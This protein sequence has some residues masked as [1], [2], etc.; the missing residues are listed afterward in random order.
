[1]PQNVT[2]VITDLISV[3]GTLHRVYRHSEEVRTKNWSDD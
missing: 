1:V 3:I 2:D